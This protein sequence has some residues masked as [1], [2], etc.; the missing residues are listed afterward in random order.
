VY[1]AL[2]ELF[3]LPLTVNFQEPSRPHR[4]PFAGKKDSIPSTRKP[5]RS[6]TSLDSYLKADLIIWVVGKIQGE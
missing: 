4:Q 5:V 2:Q 1:V 6:H 3:L